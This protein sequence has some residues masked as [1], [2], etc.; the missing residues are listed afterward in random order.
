MPKRTKVYGLL[1]EYERYRASGEIGRAFVRGFSLKRGA[2]AS[3]VAH[4]AHNVVVVGTNDEDI[5]AVI[6]ALKTMQGGQVAVA[7]G[8][9]RAALPLP[10]AG[11]VSDKPLEQ[12][13]ESIDALNRAAA[14]MG[15]G[16]DA[17]FM[18]L[19]FL[20]LSPIP[21]LKLTDQGLVD[22]T[23]LRITGLFE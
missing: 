10:I 15:C 6:E 21:K 23:H 22:A 2:M 13:I 18:T 16:L 19:S 5:V 8:E 4:D 3:S 20:S 1:A 11:L 17:P 7:G 9:I 14:E 12:V